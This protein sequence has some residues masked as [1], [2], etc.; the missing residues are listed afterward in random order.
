ML[1]SSVRDYI[2]STQVNLVD[3]AS[4]TSDPT[5]TNTVIFRA[6][7]A[8]SGSIEY[9]SSLTVRDTMKFSAGAFGDPSGAYGLA[10]LPF[11]GQ[12]VMLIDDN[13]GPI[14]G[15]TIDQVERDNL[16]G[17]KRQASNLNL[18]LATCSCV[19][20]DLLLYKR[21][22]QGQTYSN[23]TLDAIFQAIH[24]S[25]VGIGFSLDDDGIGMDLAIG[26]TIQSISSIKYDSV[27]NWFD[28]LCTMASSTDV[29]YWYT[30][31]YRVVVLAKQ[32]TT[33]APFNI[34]DSDLSDGNALVQI[35]DTDTREQY[36]NRAYVH[37]GQALTGGT[38]PDAFTGNSVARV[39]YTTHPVGSAPTINVNGTVKTVGVLG[40]DTGKDWYWN[41]D[42][43]VI[44]QDAGGVV[45]T[46]G[47][48]LNVIYQFNYNPIFLYSDDTEVGNRSDIESGTGYYEQ[49]FDASATGPGGNDG[50]AQAQATVLQYGRVPSRFEIQTYRGG[51]A[52]GQTIHIE[53]TDFGVDADFLIDSVVLTTA[54]N[55]SLWKV[56]AIDGSLINWDWR[57][58]LGGSSASSSVSGSSGGIGFDTFFKDVGGGNI[59]NTNPGAV[60]IGSF[61]AIFDDGGGIGSFALANVS[62]SQEAGFYAF[63]GLN[64]FSWFPSSQYSGRVSVAS[65]GTS[66]TWLSGTKFATFWA[67]FTNLNING[68]EYLV[69][70]VADNQHL[71]IQGFAPE[72]SSL[73]YAL[74]D[75]KAMQFTFPGEENSPV[76]SV[77]EIWTQGFLFL[78]QPKV[79]AKIGPQNWAIMGTCNVSGTSVT[80]YEGDSFD[81]RMT[82]IYISDVHYTFTYL[83]ATTGTLGSSGGTQTKV[84]YTNFQYGLAGD[85]S[86]GSSIGGG[87]INTYEAKLKL[88]RF[89]KSWMIGP[90]VSEAV[91]GS[92]SMLEL[93]GGN[94]ALTVQGSCRNTW[95]MTTGAITGINV[96]SSHVA[97]VT[98]RQTSDLW[99][100]GTQS[101]VDHGL[102][103]GTHVTLTGWTTS[104]FNSTFQVTG[105]A[106]GGFPAEVTCKFTFNAPGVAPGNYDISTDLFG[107][108]SAEPGFTFLGY[109]DSGDYAHIGAY[110]GGWKAM[111]VNEGG[112]PVWVGQSADDTSG[113]LMQLHGS[114]SF[115]GNAA[116]P[117]TSRLIMDTN[118]AQGQ[119]IVSPLSS[120]GGPGTDNT[121][122][123]N[124]GFEGN[125]FRPKSHLDYYDLTCWGTGTLPLPVHCFQIRTSSNQAV[126]THVAAGTYADGSYTDLVID[127]SNNAILTSAAVPFQVSDIGKGIT[128][129]SGSGFT[130][131]TY[132]VMHVDGIGNAT[133]NSAVGTVGSTG[134][135][136]TRTSVNGKFSFAGGLDA[137]LVRINNGFDYFDWLNEGLG[138]H[139]FNL[140]D[141]GSNAIISYSNAGGSPGAGTYAIQAFGTLIN[142]A[143]TDY[144]VGTGTLVVK[145]A[146]AIVTGT[147]NASTFD[148]TVLAGNRI[149]IEGSVTGSS[150]TYLPI[151]IEAG[152]SERLRLLTSGAFLI[153]RTTDD[154]S[155]AVLQ[156]IGS[157]NASAII[158]SYATGTNIGLQVNSGTFQVLGNGLCGAANFN[159]GSSGT[160]AWNGNASLRYNGTWPSGNVQFNDGSAWVNIAG[161]SSQWT[162]TGSDIYY[163][164]GKV[165]IGRTTSD[166][167]TAL[168][169]VDGNIHALVNS[170]SII[171]EYPFG[172]IAQLLTSLTNAFCDVVYDGSHSAT[173]QSNSSGGHIIL[174][175]G[176][177]TILVDTTLSFTSSGLL[178]VGQDF[179]DGGGLRLQV[180]GGV[181]INS[182]DLAIN[183]G[184]I[185][186]A[187]N[188]GITQVVALAKLTLGGS[189]GSLTTTGG[190]VTAYTAPT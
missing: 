72:A 69:T 92:G 73:P 127:G 159:V 167:T 53:L 148:V 23:M 179:D 93:A 154:S 121:V 59:R 97:T 67:G 108:I 122:I 180:K 143:S 43:T 96:N 12:P 160:I 25:G 134:G 100:E 147:T 118:A 135:H 4:T 19:S 80:I 42:S 11:Q 173:V 17:S 163:N 124:Q 116:T 54:D 120:A 187:G 176:A 41:Q 165:F 188:A 57:S 161:S 140:Q 164:T 21:V 155:G 111:A 85:L 171:A 70:A 128:V 78:G 77:A 83:T 60:E 126:F 32:T 3:E 91:N 113:Y 101:N 125:F 168:L 130:P 76:S 162:T 39:F 51:L 114:L 184:V 152:G 106:G 142:L 50:Q 88:D 183:T 170:A 24:D 44:T 62:A 190:V 109:V 15:G 150:T 95:Y 177:S 36:L 133:M 102:Q 14:F 138:T 66:V 94:T 61:A 33:A 107:V 98:I 75:Y 38:F 35:K 79:N 22:I 123:D 104:G 30:T 82:D 16:P 2:S 31:P 86:L 178:Y 144:G 157:I 71:T 46:S 181:S 18:I 145:R 29:W 8:L 175:G 7:S 117:F 81:A 63:S 20:W 34:D 28:N 136:A 131:G 56:T 146:L 115:N 48:T 141:S 112:S 139:A 58:T 149:I 45:L 169:Q 137:P 182:G 5:V 52:I 166:G 110:R 151:A 6:I 47:D 27:G 158:Q 26:P 186:V 105:V 10:A 65:N 68:V 156:L 89:T 174:A 172:P 49:V 64:G 129:T 99:F 74:P 185:S 90:N 119:T 153:N 1:I 37:L 132:T 9:D 84:A 87:L 55:M 13:L 103:T 40:Q 189:A